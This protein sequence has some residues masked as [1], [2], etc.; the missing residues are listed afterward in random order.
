[1]RT[2]AYKMFLK[3]GCVDEY[4]QRHNEIW[5]EIESIT[6]ASGVIEL[7][8]YLDEETLTIFV[9]QT[10]DES[11]QSV[12]DVDSHP[13]MRRWWKYMASIVESNDDSSPVISSLSKVYSLKHS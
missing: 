4:K 1:M 7:E 13:L 6:R 8:I 11:R 2:I 12:L 10:Y 3:P 9:C 5:P